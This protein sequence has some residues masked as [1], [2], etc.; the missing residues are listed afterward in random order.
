MGDLC[1]VQFSPFPN[2]LPRTAEY[3]QQSFEIAEV[4]HFRNGPL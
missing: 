4:E 3:L 2:S 1:V